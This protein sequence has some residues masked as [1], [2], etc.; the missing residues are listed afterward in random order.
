MVWLILPATDFF[1][2]FW[3]V[4]STLLYNSCHWAQMPF[5]AGLVPLRTAACFLTGREA[6]EVSLRDFL[7]VKATRFL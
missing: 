4:Y 6:Q 3:E 5:L 2:P 1:S 7:N